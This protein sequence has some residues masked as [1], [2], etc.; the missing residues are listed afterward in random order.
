MGSDIIYILPAVIIAITLHELAHGWVSVRLGD[1]TPKRQGRLTLNPL[2][3]LDP[4]GTLLLI[5]AGFGWAKPIIV[6]AR[7]YK[8]PKRGMVLVALAGPIMNLLIAFVSVFIYGVVIK[9]NLSTLELSG[10]TIGT[11][12]FLSTLISINIGLAV[13]NLL[14]IPPLDGSK[15]LTAVLPTK[16][17]FGI[18]RYE[19]YISLVLMAALIFG[20]LNVPLFFLR[21]TVTD[22]ML[23]FVF[24]VLGL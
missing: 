1:P 10:F 17:Y 21:N 12:K 4:I 11:M 19:K 7:Y 6:D 9:A 18:M 8:K 3:H 22:G 23:R 16:I 14:P 5:V 13:F 20:L 24:M 15:I 2:K